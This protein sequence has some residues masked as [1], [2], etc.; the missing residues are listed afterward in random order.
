MELSWGPG[1]RQPIILI[2]PRATSFFPLRKLKGNQ[3]I[4]KMPAV[5]LMHL[6]EEDARSDKDEESDDPGGIEGVTKEFMVHLAKAVKDAQTEEKCCYHCSSL[7]HFIWNCLLIKTSWENTQ[8][9]VR[10]GTALKREPK[11]LQQQPMHQRIPR[12]RFSRHKATPTD[13]LLESR[14]L[15][16]L[17][18]G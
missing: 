3:P 14:P 12:W 13:S 9:N 7:E 11:P 1:L 5:H 4:T 17:A 16:V 15:S 18:W 2:R 8:L 6:E 10:E